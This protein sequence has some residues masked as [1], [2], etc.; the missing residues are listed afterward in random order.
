MMLPVVHQ[1]AF[2]AM[3]KLIQYKRKEV[4][5]SPSRSGM[6][7]WKMLCFAPPEWINWLVTYQYAYIK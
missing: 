1:V 5:Y 3:I 7:C 4:N 6:K 2:V